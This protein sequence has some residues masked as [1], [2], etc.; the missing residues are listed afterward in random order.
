MEEL[1]FLVC[2]IEIIIQIISVVKFKK[3][4]DSK[5][6]NIFIGITVANF[7][8]T[9]LAYNVFA[10]N[11]LGLGGAIAC[12]FVCGFSFIS[13]VIVLIVGLISKRTIKINSVK[14]NKNSFFAGIL[15]ILLNIFVL[16]GLPSVM[17]NITLKSGEKK[18]LII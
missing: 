15:V 8:S 6:W 2:I 11:A 16:L 10:N 14:I 5:Y 3:I 13:N 4:G 9:F 7:I 12:L 1:F 18:S 17:S